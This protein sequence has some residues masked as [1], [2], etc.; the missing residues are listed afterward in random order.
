MTA[1]AI[2][3]LTEADPDRMG[4][5]SLDPLGLAS[6]A[7]RLAEA[8]APEITA[9]MNRI[10]FLTLITAGA[11]VAAE[12]GDEI[13]AD[14]RTPAYLAYEWIVV[15][16]LARRC[17]PGETEGVPGI[18]KARRAIARSKNAH[19]DAGAYLQVPKVFGF[20]GVYKRLARAVGFVDQGLLALSEGDALLRIWEREQGLRGFADRVPRTRGGKLATRLL[21]EVQRALAAG[22]VTTGPGSW[23]WSEIADAAGPDKAGRRE[24]DHIWR[25]LTS[26]D[27]PIR[28]ELI[29]NLQSISDGRELSEAGA[30][31]EIASLS[32]LGLRDRLTAID[33]YERFAWL[34]TAVFQTMLV[35]STSQGRRAILPDEF[36]DVDLIAR[37]SRELPEASR[38]AADAVA[39]V[40]EELAFEAAFARFAEPHRP[41]QLVDA[42]LEHHEAVQ[43]AKEKRPWIERV[44]PGFA[45]RPPYYTS[46]EPPIE[47]EYIHPYRV[48]AISSFIRD[49]GKT[50]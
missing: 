25:A 13:S 14:G 23:L 26:E 40:G 36:S 50:R 3:F 9:R 47:G 42:A 33:R 12:L 17:A 44:E 4:E 41:D 48:E 35:R 31:R 22:S 8:I 38:Q 19:L 49:L 39:A 43:V 7:D 11:S 6:I 15:E 37:A 28:R 29:L 21:G 20:H 46:D 16:S 18:Q 27:E 45:A 2:P 32:S 5:G 1:V 24:R 34:L 10:R 30:L